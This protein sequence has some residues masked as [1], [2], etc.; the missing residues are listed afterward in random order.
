MTGYLIVVRTFILALIFIPLIIQAQI[1]TFT[2]VSSNMGISH[3]YPFG[4]G[5]GVAFCDFDGDGK[6]D[7][8]LST[9]DGLTAHLYRNEDSTFTEM[10]GIFGIDDLF[11][12]NSLL[13][14]DYDNDGDR[15]LFIANAT[16]GNR[17][18][19]N[20]QLIFTDVTAAEG[21]TTETLGTTAVCWVDYNNDGWLD[22]YITNY[23]PSVNNLLY[24]NEQGNGFSDV[25]DQA[26]VSAPNKRPLA[27]SFLDIDNDGWQDLYLAHDRGTGNSLY[28][29][30]GDE[31]F[32]DISE[33]SNSNLVFNAMGIAIGDYNN[34]GFSDMYVTNTAAGNGFLKNNGDGTFSEIADSLGVAVEK[35]SWGANFFDYDNDSDLDLIVSVQDG[36]PSAGN[37]LFENLG[38]GSF[39]ENTNSGIHLDSD[40]SHGNAVGDFNDD[41]F[42]D[43]LILNTHPTSSKL[44]QNNGGNGNWV[45][46]LLEG[47]TSNRDGIGSRIE[48]Y[49]A[50]ERI[51]RTT[52]SG[53]S[54]LSQNSFVQ[55]I[56]VGTSDVIDSLVVLWPSGMRDVRRD[57][58]VS[59]KLTIIEG[60]PPTALNDEEAEIIAE[61]F[62][63]LDNYPNPFNNQT[64]IRY[65]LGKRSQVNLQIYNL[66]GALLQQFDLGWQGPGNY[67]HQVHFDA[68]ASGIFFYRI[69]NAVGKMVLLK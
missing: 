42:Q 45:K 38:D 11:E 60:T 53:I 10:A 13:W 22:L 34:D 19:Q 57:I 7:L 36:L 3:T 35:L 29:N 25:T 50:G 39:Q 28:L 14:G 62:T 18:Y 20:N 51:I 31:T 37:E 1:I 55:T 54:Y 6:D 61:N 21:I 58:A 63:L 64:T 4:L 16:G 30:N 52:H 56:G 46:V 23:E 67:S 41:G 48:A 12:S 47:T 69:G 44:W 59:Q 49:F 66:Q 33:A 68:A 15:D 27:A 17:L 26:G 9:D 5:A 32:T 43:I 2:D 24:R 65:I 40:N 8:S